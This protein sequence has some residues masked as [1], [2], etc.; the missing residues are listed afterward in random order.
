MPLEMQPHPALPKM[1]VRS[2][3]EMANLIEGL[4]EQMNRVR[5][6]IK[7]YEQTPN[8]STAAAMMKQSIQKAEQAMSKGDTIQMMV[9]YTDLE[10][11]KA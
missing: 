2:K 9:C 6:L 4:I 8:G 10:G 7:L 3:T 5:E 11:Y 1:D